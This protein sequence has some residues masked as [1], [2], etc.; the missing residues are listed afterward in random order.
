MPDVLL[1]GLPVIDLLEIT[2]STSAV[3][4]ITRRDQSTVSRIY[5]QASERLGL[6]FCKHRDGL[7]RAA[8]NQPLLECLRRSSQW[9]RLN[10]APEEPRWL[11]TG[12]LDLDGADLPGSGPLPQP[13]LDL[14]SPSPPA[15]DFKHCAGL[16]RQ[17]L[18]DLAVSSEPVA[19][20]SQGAGEE[21]RRIPL[22]RGRSA[23][24]W[25]LVRRDLEEHPALQSLI[26]ALQAAAAKPADLGSLG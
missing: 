13:A 7:Y 15:W 6:S 18:L 2:H 25:I 24:G 4:E 14:T 21:L 12:R 19:Q 26:S 5:R 9:L 20:P 10:Q 16:V 8:N 17:R 23:S 11:A 1:D 22:M 3:A